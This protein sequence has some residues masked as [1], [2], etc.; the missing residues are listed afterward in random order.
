MAEINL[1]FPTPIYIETELFDV[2]Q[3]KIWTNRLFELQKT[4]ESGGESWEGNTYT[5][6]GKFDLVHDEVFKPLV[7][8]ISQHVHEFT[9]AH[10]SNYFHKCNNAWGNINTANTY[11]EYH[12]HPSSVFSCVYYP[13]VPDGAGDIVFESPLL[14]DMMPIIDVNER[15]DLNFERAVFKPQ[16][17]MLIIFRSFIRHA[18]REGTNTESRVSIALNYG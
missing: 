15:N 11:Q 9:K 7:D 14:P 12:T 17:G 3:N 2:D 16:P 10:N 4:V 8:K 6:H 5:T 13:T 18:V 1:F